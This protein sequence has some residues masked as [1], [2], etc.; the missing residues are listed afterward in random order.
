LSE[1]A[2]DPTYGTNKAGNDEVKLSEEALISLS[3]FW[4]CHADSSKFI[5]KV[6]GYSRNNTGIFPLYLDERLQHSLD[7]AIAMKKL[8]ENLV[9]YSQLI[10]KEMKTHLASVMSQETV[11][12]AEVRLLQV[13]CPICKTVSIAPKIPVKGYEAV[14]RAQ[15]KAM[16]STIRESEDRINTNL[17]VLDFS[18]FMCTGLLLLSVLLFLLVWVLW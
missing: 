10:L 14:R 8:P 13:E 7:N 17:K 4:Y 11:L 3:R 9:E 5:E 15:L 6:E 12:H 16:K 18:F 1:T 2:E